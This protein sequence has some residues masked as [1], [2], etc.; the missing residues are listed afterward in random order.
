MLDKPI[1]GRVE[2]VSFPTLDVFD[3]P[4]KIDTGADLSSI[5]ATNITESDTGLSFELFG[6]ASPF[7]NGKTISIPKD[8]YTMTRVSSSFGHKEYRYRIKLPIKVA[9]KRIRATFTLSDR[10]D[11]LYPILIG[12]RMISSKFYVDVASGTPLKEA[13][14]A[15]SIKLK[16][17]LEE[18]QDK[19]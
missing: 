1:I 8:Q 9:G 3:V 7:Y 12:R 18:L 2:N 5:W 10:K 14:R 15:R 6:P 4:A 11:K 19:S 13:E 16:Q 17:E